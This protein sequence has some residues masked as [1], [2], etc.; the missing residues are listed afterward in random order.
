[1]YSDQRRPT[2]ERFLWGILRLLMGWVFFW[3]F[4]DKL[5]G[6][7]FPADPGSGWIDGSRASRIR[8]TVCQELR[9]SA[10]SILSCDDRQNHQTLLARRVDDAVRPSQTYRTLS[11]QR[12]QE[13]L[14]Q[15]G[16]VVQACDDFVCLRS[17]SRWQPIEILPSA[18]G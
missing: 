15:S 12:T 3:S 13:L 17:E 9:P 8:L 10:V 18:A 1:M 2:G 6:L 14:A 11:L 4:L 5:F 16:F 7:G